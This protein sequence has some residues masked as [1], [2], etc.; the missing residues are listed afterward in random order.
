MDRWQPAV[1]LS[2]AENLA[3][4]VPHEILRSA[5]DDDFGPSDCQKE[6]P[7]RFALRLWHPAPARDIIAP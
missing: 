4:Y 1:I 5:Q 3:Y 7:G 2:A 6:L